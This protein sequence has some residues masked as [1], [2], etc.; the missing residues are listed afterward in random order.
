MGRARL[1]RSEAALGAKHCLT[2]ST[3]RRSPSRPHQ[4][5]NKTRGRMRHCRHFSENDS[6]RLLAAIGECRRACIAANTKAPIGGPVY[7]A[8]ARLMEEIDL[9][10]E[11]LTGDRRHFWMRPHGTAGEPPKGP[12]PDTYDWTWERRKAEREHERPGED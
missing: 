4:P 7:R 10:A 6:D 2:A 11:V 12:W 5:I 8:G 1:E 3:A 9:V